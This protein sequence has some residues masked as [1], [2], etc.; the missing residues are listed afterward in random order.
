MKLF[1]NYGKSAK[2]ILENLSKLLKAK[3][4]YYCGCFKSNNFENPTLN[5]IFI[6]NKKNNNGFISIWR[7][8]NGIEIYDLKDKKKIS[9][10]RKQF[11]ENINFQKNF[12]VLSTKERFGKSSYYY[13]S[14]NILK[15]IEEN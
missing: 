10:K 13:L 3:S 7:N 5:K 11:I 12:Y 8:T 2:E 9:L 14:E 6:Y 1:E 4:L 15:K